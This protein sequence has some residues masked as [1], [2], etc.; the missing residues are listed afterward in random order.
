MTKLAVIGGGAWGT[1][2]AALACKAATGAEE[3]VLWARDETV[4]ET[5]NEGRGNPGYLPDVSLPPALKA[6]ADLR[7]AVDGADIVLLV[8]PAQALRAVTRSLTASL[9]PNAVL[10]SCAKGVEQGDLKPMTAVLAEEAP[11]HSALVLSGP[12][13]AREA[14]LD[15]PTAFVVAGGERSI[16]DRVCARIALPTFRPYASD[17]VVAVEMGGAVKNVLA[18]ACGVVSG[19]DLGENAKAALITRGLAETGR[20][21]SALGGR[22]ET[23][24]GLSGMGDLVL[25]AG[26]L[27]SRN[28][29]LG[30][31]LGQG[32]SL[33][34]VL[35]SR[36]TVTEG[37]WTASAI[38]EMARKHG[39]DMPI[40]SAVNEIVTNGKDID[41]VIGGL[42]SRP[43]KEE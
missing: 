8:T 34:A 26:S 12:T 13:F 21:I 30:Y 42:L 29:S 23:L 27:Q 37:V 6:T 18:I 11:A 41:T 24:N 43:L 31:A 1:A 17:D 14:A 33:E 5:I 20:L 10:V 7:D 3:T 39:V 15:K 16:V 38:T 32:K 19:R 40:C 36:H 4:V 2:L 28:M 22:M 25:T 9:A 35:G